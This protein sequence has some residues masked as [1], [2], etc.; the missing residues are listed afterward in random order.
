MKL[1]AR[2]YISAD[3]SPDMTTSLTQGSP[4]N[5]SNVSMMTD[6]RYHHRYHHRK[7]YIT[8]IT[9]GGTTA[10]QRVWFSGLMSGRHHPLSPI[11][12]FKADCQQQW[13]VALTSV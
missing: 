1:H 6:N 8:L 12:D 2:Q 13:A 4:Y 10:V 11:T 3:V 9:Q 7:L 5:H